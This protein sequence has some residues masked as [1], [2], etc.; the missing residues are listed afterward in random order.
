ML[1]AARRAAQSATRHHVQQQ[2]R[3]VDCQTQSPTAPSIRLSFGSCDALEPAIRPIRRRPNVYWPIRYRALASQ[4]AHC[5][6]VLNGVRMLPL[7]GRRKPKPPLIGRRRGLMVGAAAAFVT[8][9]SLLLAGTQTI[10]RTPDVMSVLLSDV[11]GDQ[12]GTAL[13]GHAGPISSVAFSPGGGTLATATENGTV[14]LW[15]VRSSTLVETLRGLSGI[16]DS[17]AFSSHPRTL[18]AGG[19]DGAVLLW[20]V[21]S[22]TDLGTAL[23]AHA[24]SVYSVSFSPDGRTLA[25]ASADGTVVLWDVRRHT[26]LGTLNNHAGAIS[27][28][29]F[30]PH[31]STLAAAD[32]DGTVVLWD[33]R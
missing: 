24:G 17:V 2:S 31:G 9:G 29:A 19:R 23:K 14:Q 8:A 11:H 4:T 18:A 7:L 6:T 30:R 13:N 21:A 26:W 25:A 22:R 3:P 27:S 33:V 16:V 5:D 28:V 1:A 15:D 10:A 12:L 32:I 20:N